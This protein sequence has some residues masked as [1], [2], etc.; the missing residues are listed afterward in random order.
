MDSSHSDSSREGLHP[1]EPPRL[2]QIWIGYAFALAAMGAELVTAALHPEMVN[3][4]RMTP[5]LYLFLFVFVGLVYW[6]VCIHR[7]HVVMQHVPG[8]KHPISPA[9]AVGFHF[10]P[11]YYL[12]WVFK[13]PKEIARFVNLRLQREVMKYQIPGVISLIA[14][15]VGPLFDPPLGLFLLFFSISY[16]TAW[17]RRALATPPEPGT[18]EPLA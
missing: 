9:R 13:W 5:P 10:L 15:L 17:L 14:F 12:Y 18:A 6:L 16:V 8:W 1:Q 4:E 11:I 7:L 2:P 3:A